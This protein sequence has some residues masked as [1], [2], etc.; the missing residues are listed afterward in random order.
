MREYLLFRVYGTI[1]SWG[2]I[3]VGEIRPT[4]QHPSKSAVIG[5]ISASFGYKREQV[6]EISLL[7]A[8]VGY[9][10]RV[11]AEGIPLR[12]YH[13][14]Q[15]PD[16]GTG[17]NARTFYTR[18][19]ELLHDKI[20]TSLSSRDYRTDAL[21]TVCLWLKDGAS[22]TLTSIEE[23]L[24]NPVFQQYFGRKSCVISLPI[25]G[26]IHIAESIA[27]AFEEISLLDEKLFLWNTFRKGSHTRYF[28]EECNHHGFPKDSLRMKTL[29]RDEPRS[30]TR[31]Q[32]GERYEYSAVISNKQEQ[33]ANDE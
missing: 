13:T 21:Y 27:S 24:R 23:R 26:Q 19:E 30:R 11:D 3:T 32:F 10:V 31:W 33:E 28:W 4:A 5:L 8:S 9:A 17:R 1:V 20:D 6:E 7:S 12:D 16:S 18:R 2:D 14:S 25:H 22:I 29:R 15:K